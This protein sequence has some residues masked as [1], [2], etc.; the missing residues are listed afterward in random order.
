MFQVKGYIF[1]ASH[2]ITDNARKRYLSLVDAD[3]MH[4]RT[5]LI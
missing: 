3:R 2:K 1:N 4:N 5:N